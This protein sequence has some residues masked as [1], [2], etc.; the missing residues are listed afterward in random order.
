[1]VTHDTRLKPCPFCGG[2]GKVHEHPFMSIPN[3]YGVKCAVCKCQT[4]QFFNS[5]LEAI[6]AWNRRVNHEEA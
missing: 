3:S 5:E 6:E 2:E 1:M 4:S